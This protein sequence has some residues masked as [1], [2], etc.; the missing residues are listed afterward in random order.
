SFCIRARTMGRMTSNRRWADMK[1]YLTA[2]VVTGPL[3]VGLFVVE[4][5]VAQKPGGVLRVYHWDSPA[6]MSIHEEATY[7]TVVPMMGV[8]NNLV[9]YKQDEPRNSLG[10]IVPDLATQWSWSEDGTQLTFELRKGVKWHDG[11]PFSANDVKCTWDAL[12]GKS[13][14]TLRTNPRK[15]WYDNLEQVVTDG[16]ESVTFQLKRPQPA[17]LAFLASGFSP[18]YPCHVALRE[19]RQRPI[20][21]GPFK[22]VEF[23]ANESIKVTRNPDY[24]RAGRPTST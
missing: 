16:D 6:S 1:R 23:K 3:L 17:F 19:M 12:L 13:T 9:I 7:S 18:V 20:G 2:F 8:F 14:A 11:A 21:T 4:P 24:W 15:L 5:A 22:F 10:S